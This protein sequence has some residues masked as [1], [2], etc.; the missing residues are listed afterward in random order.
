L[1]FKI[2]KEWKDVVLYSWSVRA[3]AFLSVLV[4]IF[5]QHDLLALG[6]LSFLPTAMS[7]AVGAAVVGFLILG[8]PIILARITEQP[9]LVERIKSHEDS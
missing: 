9:K 1:V 2:I 6:L 8:L 3:S 5:G 7:Q 4:G